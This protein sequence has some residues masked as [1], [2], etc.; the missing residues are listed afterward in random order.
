MK[1]SKI[2]ALTCTLGFLLI[3]GITGCSDSNEEKQTQKEVSTKT[4]EAPKIEVV[5]NKDAHAIKVAV[6]K[7]DNNQSKSYYYDYN[8]K[9]AY[10]ENSRPANKD[11]S[12]RVKPRSN[13]DANMHIRSPYD[14]VQVSML[15]KKLSKEF[16][17]KCSA[18]HNDY[19]NGVIGPSLLG[20]DSSYIYNKIMSFKTG[21]KSNPLM[22][23]LVKMMDEAKIKKLAQE[24]FEFNKE[25][26]QMRK[27]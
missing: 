21:E 9:S 15:V 6:K 7:N 19:A 26:N 12:V 4:A 10:D 1:K 17:V 24:I 25:I 8:V 13:I 20:K 16:I 18:C 11:A 2:Q 14:K 27:K 5:Q 23:D 22:N 3:T